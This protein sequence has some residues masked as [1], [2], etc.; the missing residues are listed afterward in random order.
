MSIEKAKEHLKAK[1]YLDRLIEPEA[2]SATVELAAEALGCRPA[3]IAKTLSFLVG[4][5][6]VM[7]LAAGTARVDNR[8]FKDTFHTKAKM[9]PFDQVEELTGHAPGGVCPFG[10][11]TGV[12]VYLDESL[13]AYEYV[14]PAAGNDHSGVKLTVSELEDCA[15]ALGWVDVCKEAM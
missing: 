2:S 9:I 11:N 8:K 4:E 1:G 15:D 6:P 7:V 13:K 10:A 5:K 14:Y 12:R 3:E